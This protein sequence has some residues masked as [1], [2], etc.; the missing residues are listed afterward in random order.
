MA[1]L[2]L[3][4]MAGPTDDCWHADTAF[5]QTELRSAIRTGTAA[6]FM[7]PLLSRMAVVGLTMLGSFFVAIMFGMLAVQSYLA[8]QQMRGGGGFG[9]GRPW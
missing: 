7:S 2:A 8:I 1:H 4:Q 9:G 3:R 6:A 5:E